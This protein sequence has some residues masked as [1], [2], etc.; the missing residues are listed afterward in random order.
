M[1]GAALNPYILKA[2]ISVEDEAQQMFSYHA[3]SLTYSQLFTTF[4][5]SNFVA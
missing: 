3:A 5:F 2:S 1:Q 4:M